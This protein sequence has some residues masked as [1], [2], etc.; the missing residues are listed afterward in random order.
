MKHPFDQIKENWVF[1]TFIGGLII[2]YANVNS[3]IVQAQ[4]DIADLKVVSAEI[5]AIKVDIGSIKTSLDFIKQRV[6]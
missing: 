2:W 1:A 5:S 6:R 3:K 4:S